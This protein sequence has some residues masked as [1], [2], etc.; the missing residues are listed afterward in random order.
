MKKVN[1]NELR[2]VD[3][4]YRLICS[5]CGKESGSVGPVKSSWFHSAH[6]HGKRGGYA[7]WDLR[8]RGA[9]SWWS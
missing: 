1:E 2:V 8:Y 7:M 3:G 9:S 4:G 5:L 6:K